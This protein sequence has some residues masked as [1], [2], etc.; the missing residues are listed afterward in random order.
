MTVRVRSI[1]PGAPFLRA[2]VASCIDGS[3]GIAFPSNGRDYSS[4]TIYV[5]TRR[6]A[7]A[8]A[9]AFAEALQPRA[10]LLPRIVPLGDPADLEERAIL[11]GDGFGT[12]DDIAPAIGDLERRLLLTPL[13][14]TWRNSRDLQELAR[15]GDGF[16]LGGGF[17]D[18]FSLAGDLAALIDEFAIEGVDWHRIKTLTDG[19]FDV[20]WSM[21]RSFLEI[22]GE[23]WPQKLAAM[24]QLDPC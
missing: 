11:T 10:V 12:P 17:P 3:L 1:A 15:S 18:S 13:I 20:Y 16:S 7:R 22:A 8:L 9:H 19:Q 14:E 23:A 4:A 2:L 24:G 6:A 5:P 21:T